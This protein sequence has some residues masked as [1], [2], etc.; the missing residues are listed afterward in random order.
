MEINLTTPALLFPAISL[1][2]LA[3]TNRFL[4]LA[5]LIRTLDERYRKERD[6]RVLLQI[7]KLRS[8][9]LLIRAMQQL[10]VGS[11]LLCVICMFALFAGWESV[12]QGAF[13]VQL[14]SDD[15]LAGGEPLGDSALR[16]R[17]EYPARRPGA[18]ARSKAGLISRSGE[19]RV[20][21][22]AKARP[23]RRLCV[24]VCGFQQVDREPRRE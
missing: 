23:V 11:L 5:A 1:L 4:A 24:D 18:G 8:R 19:E 17:A 22:S 12:R 3:Y 21:L 2:L 13:R 7:G 15:A 20:P 14:D 10:G 16:Q 6:E 9:V